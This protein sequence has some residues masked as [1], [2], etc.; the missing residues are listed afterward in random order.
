MLKFKK[1][2]INRFVYEYMYM[3]LVATKLLVN[4]YSKLILLNLVSNL[5][6]L[7]VFNFFRLFNRFQEYFY[8]LCITLL[9][10]IKNSN[11]SQKE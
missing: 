2:Y 1:N 10:I 3:S 4:I 11:F 5:K 9:Q 8:Q 6:S 7:L